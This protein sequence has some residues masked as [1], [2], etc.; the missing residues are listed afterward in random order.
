M[1]WEASQTDGAKLKGMYFYLLG[2]GGQESRK[3]SWLLRGAFR[4]E[5]TK[6][7]AMMELGGGNSVGG[8]NETL[9]EMAWKESEL[10]T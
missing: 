8:R 9:Q 5:A 10:S 7:H 4:Q 2:S 6:A 3:P 1:G